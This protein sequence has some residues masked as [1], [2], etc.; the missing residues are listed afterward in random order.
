MAEI[1]EVRKPSR[2]E[3]AEADAGATGSC[4]ADPERK[5]D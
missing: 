5:D 2:G 1:T 3:S 4:E